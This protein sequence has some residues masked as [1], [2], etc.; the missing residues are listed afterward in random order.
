MSLHQAV[1]TNNINV[2]KKHISEG[3]NLDEKEQEGGSTPLISACVFG[4][5]EIALL[6]INAGV[7]INVTNNDGS[8]ALHTAAIFLPN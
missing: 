2:V 3:K 6:L 5:T 4:K 7:D 8:T 1:I